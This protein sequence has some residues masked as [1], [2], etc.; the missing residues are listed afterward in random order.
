MLKIT[1][2]PENAQII[3]VSLHGQFTGD[4]VP[5]IE[6]ALSENGCTECQVILDL[7]NVTLVDRGAMEFL[8]RVDSK[9][10]RLENTP[11]YVTRWIEQEVS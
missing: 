3:T 8:C 7:T 1:K 4:Y 2:Q 6:K 5:L 9:K 10:I 11:S